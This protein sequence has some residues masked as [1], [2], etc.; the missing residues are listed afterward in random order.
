ML[1]QICPA[2]LLWTVVSLNS[3]IGEVVT[4]RLFVLTS[5]FIVTE[6]GN[7]P[8]LFS[9]L[10]ENDLERLERCQQPFCPWC[11]L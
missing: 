7:P 10:E 4:S 1:V 3:R 8:A 11:S 5:S 2:S 9:D 6:F